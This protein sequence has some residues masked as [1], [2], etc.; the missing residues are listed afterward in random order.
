MQQMADDSVDLIIADP[1]YNLSKGSRVSITR[2]QKLPGMGGSWSKAMESWDNIDLSDYL[3]FTL[4]WLQECRRILKPSGS[5][6]IFGSYHNIGIANVACQLLQL[7]IINEVVWY[8]RNAFPNLAGRRLTASHETL[9]WVHK[10][11]EKNRQYYFNYEFSKDGNFSY[12]SLKS[13]GK[14]MRTVWEISNNKER[15]ELEFGKHPTQKPL[16]VLKRMIELTSKPGDL[17]FTPFA[18]AGS[19]C[20]AAVETGRS[21][22]G[23]ELEEEYVDIAKLRLE[24]ANPPLSAD[25]LSESN[26]ENEGLF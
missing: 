20:L 19:E 10:G 17:V 24:N 8:K 23:I 18:G 21:Y 13:P 26:L 7:E 9:L 3:T 12:D 1:P 4:S 2:E 15:R 6:W 22:L 16:R 25:M 5:M 11:T 14:Q